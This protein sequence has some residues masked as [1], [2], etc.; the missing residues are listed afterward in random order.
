MHNAA[1]HIARSFRRG[2]RR[3]TWFAIGKHFRNKVGLRCVTSASMVRSESMPYALDGFHRLDARDTKY[4]FDLDADIPWHRIDEPGA[5][6][7]RSWIDETGLRGEA[8]AG[9]EP[10]RVFDWAFGAA[11]AE[12]F[13][14]TE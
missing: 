14:A 13:F 5:H 11:T 3:K 6:V 1:N 2:S 4:R 10:R 12:L 9:D 7:P 8:L